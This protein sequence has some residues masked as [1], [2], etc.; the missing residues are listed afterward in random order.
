MMPA[1]PVGRVAIDTG[2]GQIALPNLQVYT[3]QDYPV[4]NAPLRFGILVLD[5]VVIGTILNP[6][7]SK[8]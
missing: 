1:Q 6:E 4:R 8:P 2:N 7:S 3:T 5:D